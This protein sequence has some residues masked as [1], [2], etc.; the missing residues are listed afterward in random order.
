MGRQRTMYR[1]HNRYVNGNTTV[2]YGLVSEDGKQIRAT[3]VQMAYYVGRDQVIN[4]AGQVYEDKVL[5]RGV[6]CDIR[7]LPVVKIDSPK[8]AEQA[9][10]SNAGRPANI[11]AGTRQRAAVDTEKIKEI[12]KYF[13]DSLVK[14]FD[15]TTYQIVKIMEPLRQEVDS[16]S[17][18]KATMTICVKAPRVKSP[19]QVKLV[20]FVD[21]RLVTNVAIAVN[22]DGTTKTFKKTC[23]NSIKL[24]SFADDCLGDLV[25]CIIASVNEVRGARAAERSAK[26]SEEAASRSVSMPEV[27]I[28]NK[29]VD[30]GGSDTNYEENVKD[31]SEQARRLYFGID[32]K[33]KPLLRDVNTGSFLHVIHT[34]GKA[35]YCYVNKWGSAEPEFL[36]MPIWDYMVLE[37]E[38]KEL[39]KPPV[40]DIVYRA[41]SY[42]N[43]SYGDVAIRLGL[44][45]KLG[46][47]LFDKKYFMGINSKCFN[48]KLP[49]KTTIMHS[50]S[51][52]LTS[53]EI[54]QTEQLHQGIAG[55]YPETVSGNTNPT[56]LIGPTGIDTSYSS[57]CLLLHSMIHQYISMMGGS[58]AD[59]N[60][61]DQ[62]FLNLASKTSDIIK[63]S[64]I[65]VLGLK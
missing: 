49:A 64:Y 31:L 35:A 13:F 19:A 65:D 29:T 18:C 5:F 50:K 9:Q 48:N 26:R 16:N 21:P 15:D 57:K 34:N 36:K 23:D 62:D 40:Q 17:V 61:H 11:T 22:F 24:E 55:Y 47:T 58:S 51:M 7:A 37:Y 3:E 8:V 20:S 14:G 60:V 56:I 28:G 46:Q 53:G 44:H 45:S 33:D 39:I 4:V 1:L 38:Y 52:K 63:L 27:S 54:V 32:V 42:K 25:R 59:M 41:N 2:Y 43:V 30:L 10:R 12:S 6:G